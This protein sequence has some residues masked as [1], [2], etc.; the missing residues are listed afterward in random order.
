MLRVPVAGMLRWIGSGFAVWMLPDLDW[1]KDGNRWAGWTAIKKQPE[2]RA[3]HH[4]SLSPAREASPANRNQAMNR[5]CRAVIWPER[6][7]VETSGLVRAARL[8][9]VTRGLVNSGP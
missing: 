4:G 6:G 8:N 2:G 5:R 1:W 7:C 3:C 9:A